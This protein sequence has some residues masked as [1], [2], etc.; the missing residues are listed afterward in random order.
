MLNI[1]GPEYDFGNVVFVVLE[2][3]E[4]RRRSFDDESFAKQTREVLREKLSKIK[5]AYDEFGGSPVYW[6]ALEKE[7]L[8]T[9]LPQ[10]VESA[11]EMTRLERAAFDVWRGGD[12]AARG[13]FALGGLLLGSII[14][15]L[16]LI[17]TLENLF[18]LGLAGAGALYPEIKRY[19]HERRHAKALN[20]LV[21][22]A[23][24]YQQNARLHYMT[25]RD[26]RESFS[27]GEPELLDGT[28]TSRETE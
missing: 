21:T 22:S 18:V 24:K 3:A 6:A 17:A 26:I 10:Y 7:V 1:A 28:T 25:T 27:V 12:P 2:E 13:A 9:V 16:P 19:T 5:A 14:K 8:E 15:P 20:R 23:A 11:R 4:H